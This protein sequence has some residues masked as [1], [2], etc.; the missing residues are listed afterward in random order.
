LATGF[1]QAFFTTRLSRTTQS[2]NKSSNFL[3]SLIAK[4]KPTQNPYGR[5]CFKRTGSR[6]E[7]RSQTTFFFGSAFLLRTLTGFTRSRSNTQTNGSSPSSRA[8]C[9]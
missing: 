2:R 4:A 8:Q 3:D 7:S 9:A 6:T 1:H 5:V